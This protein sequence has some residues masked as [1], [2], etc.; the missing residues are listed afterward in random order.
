M[1]RAGVIRVL[2]AEPMKLPA[3]ARVST[4]AMPLHDRSGKIFGVAQI[5]NRNDGE[6]FDLDD[7][8]RFHNFLQLVGVLLE[9]W[10]NMRLGDFE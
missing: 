10:R 1:N 4:L 3:T 2:I 5:L 9:T 7:E 6:P 8:Q